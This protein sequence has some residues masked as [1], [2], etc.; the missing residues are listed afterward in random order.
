MNAGAA[1]IVV[2][3]FVQNGFDALDAMLGLSFS[4]DAAEPDDIT[5]EEIGGIAEEHPV[6][7]RAKII[8]GGSVALVFQ[9]SDAAKLIGLLTSVEDKTDLEEGDAGMLQEI[10][11]AVL[12]AGIAAISDLFDDED[13]ELES[14]EVVW[15]QDAAGLADFIGAPATGS[16]V[17]FSADPHFDST[18][19]LL[20]TQVF[21]ERMPGGDGGGEDAVEEP[22]VSKAEMKDILE[23]FTPDDEPDHAAGPSGPSGPLPENLAVIMD[24]EL[25]ATAR[26]GK[27]EIPL[28]EIL[29]FGPGSIIEVGHLIDEPVE[30]LVNDKLIARGDVVVVDEKFGLRI[31]EIVSPEERIESLR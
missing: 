11:D 7:M 24:I 18:V 12:G 20:Y 15:G 10:A 13:V 17:S 1:K 5:A 28:S 2:D 6:W 3:S 25:I 4:K 9:L 27:V 29:N 8:G 16:R 22:L 30:L 26:L 14:V 31:T 23:G 21:E 19:A